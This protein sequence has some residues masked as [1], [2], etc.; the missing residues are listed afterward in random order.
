M[1]VTVVKST[2]LSTV[3]FDDPKFVMASFRKWIA[4]TSRGRPMFISDNNGFDWQFIHNEI[5][6]ERVRIVN[7]AS[8][9]KGMAL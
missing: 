7:I 4:A 8:K 9:R 1:V 5:M 6:L 3:T 2:N